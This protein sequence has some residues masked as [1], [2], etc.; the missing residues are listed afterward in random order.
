[1][2]VGDI[3]VSDSGRDVEHDNTALPI[4]VVSITESTELLLTGGIPHI[5]L[6]FTEVGVEPERAVIKQTGQLAYSLTTR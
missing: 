3:L 4:D 5:E 1:V 2:P 6:E